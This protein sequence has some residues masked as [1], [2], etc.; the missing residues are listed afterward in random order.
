MTGVV[1]F[2]F[3]VYLAELYEFTNI[4]ECGYFIFIQEYD[5]KLN[6]DEKKHPVLWY[7]FPASPSNWNE[8]VSDTEGTSETSVPSVN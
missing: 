8:D 4:K 6:E 3:S 5:L 7:E 1:Y 2:C